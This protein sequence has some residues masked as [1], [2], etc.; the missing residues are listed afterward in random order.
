MIRRQ[1]Y[2]IV[3]KYFVRNDSIPDRL[4]HLSRGTLV[5][6]LLLLMAGQYVP[7][8]FAYQNLV[9][10]DFESYP[11][12]G[13]PSRWYV[14]HGKKLIPITTQAMSDVESFFILE[15]G[16]NKF[17]RATT[18]DQAMRIIFANGDQFEWSLRKHPKLAWDWRAIS[19]PEGA[20]EHTDR[21]ND[22]GGAVYVVFSSDFLG[23]PRS[24]K[25]TYSTTLPVGTRASYGSLK[26]LV[27]ASA[28]D[29]IGKW[30]HIERDMYADYQQ[31]FGKT[32]PDNPLAIFLWSDSD[33]MND[34]A[35]VDFDNV[36]L[37]GQ[38][39]RE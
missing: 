17:V 37:L 29:G 30:L 14:N 31:L 16:G 6:L 27:V 39:G 35:I 33:T 5:W 3:I 26:V 4:W 9:L 34:R 18:I 13:V 36:T 10:D 1:Y 19:L 11:E 32:P 2:K 22:T 8:A 25:Y 38:V 15:E 20:A 21:H 12:G 24:I 23:R 28:L 7:S